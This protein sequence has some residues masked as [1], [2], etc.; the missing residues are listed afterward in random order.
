MHLVLNELARKALLSFNIDIA[1]FQF[2][3]IE[4]PLASK[5]AII[6][7]T[8]IYIVIVVFYQ[9]LPISKAPA[10]ASTSNLAA[11]AAAAVTSDTKVS[12]ES[13]SM[14]MTLFRAHNLFLALFSG[15]MLV[16]IVE[17]IGQLMLEKGLFYTICDQ[18]VNRL[19]TPFED[20]SLDYTRYLEFWHYLNFLTKYYEWVDTAF[21]MWKRKPLKF[22]HWYHHALTAVLAWSNLY[23][24]T[25]MQWLVITLNLFV[26]VIMYYYYYL[27]AVP[28]PPKIWWKQHITT[29]QI[30]QFV[31][32]LGFVGYGYSL[33][34]RY[35]AEFARRGG[36]MTQEEAA[37]DG[38]FYCAGRDPWALFSLLLLASYLLLFI[39]FFART[40]LVK[41]TKSESKDKAI[42]KE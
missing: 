16:M 26:H 10:S 13:S 28:S 31:L 8:C 22:L 15:L 3:V 40:Y 20:G 24:Q 12:D 7:L 23:S 4:S 33:L 25:T 18:Q 19:D 21:L 27:T 34:Y 32:D 2:S 39:D 9:L 38:I 11:G 35:N 6:S 17:I 30:S 37:R 5:E 41:K 36:N 29:L 14:Q 42:K 1:T